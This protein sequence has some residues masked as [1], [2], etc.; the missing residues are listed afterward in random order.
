MKMKDV[1]ITQE[2]HK[3]LK[4]ESIKRKKT[5]SPCRSICDIASEC[6]MNELANNIKQLKIKEEEQ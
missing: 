1:R 4:K 6:I 2:A 5:H 3:I